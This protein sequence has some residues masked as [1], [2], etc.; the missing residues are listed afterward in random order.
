MFSGSCDVETYCIEQRTNCYIVDVITVIFV[1][2]DCEKQFNSADKRSV[3]LTFK[4]IAHYVICYSC[5]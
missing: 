2:D 4:K 5:C 1:V 3:I